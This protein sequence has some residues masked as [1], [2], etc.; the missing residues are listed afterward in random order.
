MPMIVTDKQL[1]ETVP[2]HVGERIIVRLKEN[3]TTGYLWRLEKMPQESVR[4]LD[5]HFRPSQVTAR[6]ANGAGGVREFAFEPRR[7]GEIVI[8]LRKSFGDCEECDDQRAR[9]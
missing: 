2:A 3:P 7:V 9:L 6:G 5:Q 4:L 1:G 8:D